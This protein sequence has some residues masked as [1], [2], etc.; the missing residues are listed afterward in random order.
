MRECRN[1]KAYNIQHIRMVV[2][3]AQQ[4]EFNVPKL[5]TL[6]V[7]QM[8]N[9]MFSMFSAIKKQKCTRYS[10]AASSNLPCTWK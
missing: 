9:V 6:K 7:V 10:L 1:C 2:M 8:V 5:Y 3:V 4:W